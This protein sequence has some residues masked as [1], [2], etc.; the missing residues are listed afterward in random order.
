M[1]SNDGNKNSVSIEFVTLKRVPSPFEVETRDMTH[2]NSRGCPDSLWRS[3][4]IS[5]L[6]NT[7]GGNTGNGHSSLTTF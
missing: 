2:L 5:A 4:L 7:A 1:E 6:R 3:V